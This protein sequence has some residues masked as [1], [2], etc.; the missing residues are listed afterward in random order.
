L[1]AV[2]ASFVLRARNRH[3][4]RIAVIESRDENADGIPDV[5][6]SPPSGQT[7]T[8]EDDA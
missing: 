3:Y 5:F 7:E 1:A 8:T 4:G 6:Q 2:L